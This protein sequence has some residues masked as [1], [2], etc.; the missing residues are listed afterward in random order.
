MI[1]SEKEE[2]NRR[3]I[4]N[5]TNLVM[6]EER[7]GKKQMSERRTGGWY[8]EMMSGQVRGIADR[9]S[10]WKRRS[11]RRRRR[12]GG[13]SI[14]SRV[15]SK[16]LSHS[17]SENLC[18][19][20]DHYMYKMEGQKKGGQKVNVISFCGV[21]HIY[22]E[23]IL[24]SDCLVFVFIF[25]FVFVF[26]SLL[27][28]SQCHLSLLI[29]CFVSSS[30]V[31]YSD[32]FS[33]FFS[34]LFFCFL[35]CLSILCLIY[36]YCYCTL[37]TLRDARYEIYVTTS[38]RH[39]SGDISAKAQSCWRITIRFYLNEFYFTNSFNLLRTYINQQCCIKYCKTNIYNHIKCN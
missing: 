17:D 33:V 29:I 25:T 19:T 6:K 21:N 3:E 15:F 18:E 38:V 4:G 1:C 12:R 32:Y 20:A 22:W 14:L 5:R 13:L 11:R 23:N 31:R 27:I 37:R 8:Q 16:F 35:S 28:S 34:S 10:R 36:Y 26:Y 39:G 24:V 2:Q 30:I 9:C 7:E